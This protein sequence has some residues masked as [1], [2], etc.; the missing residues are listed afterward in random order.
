M[1]FVVDDLRPDLEIYNYNRVTA[2]NLAELAK[3]GVI[4]DKCISTSGWTLPSIASILTGLQP[5]D[6]GLIN[7]NH[8]LTK[9]KIG[10]YLGS[11]YFRV[12]IVNNGNLISDGITDNEIEKEGFSRRPKAWK[13]FGWDDGFDQ[14]FWSPREDHDT[15][16]Q[17]ASQFFDKLDSGEI[18]K[19]YFLFFHTNIVHDYDMNGAEYLDVERWLGSPL[20]S[21]LHEFKDGP[22]VWQDPPAELSVIELKQQI[23]AKYDAGIYH[24]DKLLPIIMD[25]IDFSETIVVLMSDHGEGFNPELGRV[26]HLVGFTMIFCMYLW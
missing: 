9:P 24:F 5:E 14:Y 8:R 16:F 25:R 10:H 19:P 7:H 21:E 15:P 26:H 6:H 12:A 11:D 2:P 23:K 4:F 1:L 22:S 17:R 3:T 18:T 13:K 20:R